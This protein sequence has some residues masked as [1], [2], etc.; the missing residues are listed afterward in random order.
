MSKKEEVKTNIELLRALILA[1]LTA[2]FGVCGFAFLQRR[3]LNLYEFIFLAVV[4]VFL[5]GVICLCGVLYDRQRKQ[6]RDL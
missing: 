3:E 2:L 6:L 5:A 4:V 1:F